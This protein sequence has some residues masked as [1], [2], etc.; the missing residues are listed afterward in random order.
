[1]FLLRYFPVRH[2]VTE[3]STWKR[4]GNVITEEI[5]GP[6][7]TRHPIRF[8]F[9]DT[10][11]KIILQAHNEFGYSSEAVLVIRAIKGKAWPLN[12]GSGGDFTASQLPLVP[13]IGA[14]VCVFLICIILVDLS[15]YKINK[16]GVTHFLCE[17]TKSF[18]KFNAQSESAKLSGQSLTSTNT[19]QGF[20]NG[21]KENSPLLE[22]TPNRV[23]L[24]D[25]SVIVNSDS[26][27]SFRV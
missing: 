20:G 14:L 19:L 27:G 8:P 6:G 7:T 10:Y 16:T 3:E 11:V 24:V 4:T 5:S 25:N 15:C 17:K 12:N 22:A 23:K 9:S 26:S 18:K 1:M 21:I 2:E 13:I